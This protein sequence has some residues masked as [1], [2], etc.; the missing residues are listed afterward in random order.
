MESTLSCDP[1]SLSIIHPVDE[2]NSVV[3]IPLASYISVERDAFRERYE[4]AWY[5]AAKNRLSSELSAVIDR[6][7]EWGK[8][9]GGLGVSGPIAD[10]ILHHYE[11]CRLKCATYIGRGYLIDQTLNFIYTET[12]RSVRVGT[13]G[14]IDGATVGR[15]GSVS[16][17][18]VI[19]QDQ[20]FHLG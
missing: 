15:S 7:K 19:Y 9:A 12:P 17:I 6:C 4:N 8:S 13:S 10:D 3:S 14:S 2:N 18:S 1:N 5:I 11:F 16:V 20:H